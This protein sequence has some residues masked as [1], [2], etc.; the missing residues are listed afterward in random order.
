MEITLQ[1]ALRI[2]ARVTPEAWQE[3]EAKYRQHLRRTMAID[4]EQSI[5][6]MY[7]CWY[8][9]ATKQMFDDDTLYPSSYGERLERVI[10]EHVD[11]SLDVIAQIVCD[12]L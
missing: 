7:E 5:I 11:R 10:D 6:G 9:N 12:T 8:W 4:S 2:K 3:A 1:D